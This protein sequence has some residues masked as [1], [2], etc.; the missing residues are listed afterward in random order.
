MTQTGPAADAHAARRTY[1]TFTDEERGDRGR[2]GRARRP[3]RAR[4]GGRVPGGR[5]PA[6]RPVDPR[7]A[8]VRGPARRE[9]A[10][11]ELQHV[12]KT[13]EEKINDAASR[14]A[15]SR[16]PRSSARSSPGDLVSLHPD[17]GAG[18]KTARKIYDELGI[19]TLDELRAAAESGTLQSIPGPRPEGG[20]EHPP[21]ARAGGAEAERRSR[22]LLSAVLAH[23][24]ADRRGAARASRRGPGRD[25]RQR[26]ADDRHL[27]GPRHRRD[28]ARRGRADRG[29]HGA[30]AGR[31]GAR[32][33]AR[34]A[35]GCV[36]HNGL[37]VDFR[38]VAPE[39]FGNVLQHL[40]GSKQHNMALR[41]YA[42]RR[43]QH[44]SEYGIEDDSDGAKHTCATEQE[45]YALLGLDYIE[46][47]LR[48]GRGELKAA[49]EHTLPSWSRGT[50]LAGDLHCHTTLRTAAA[51]SRRWRRRPRSA[52]TSISRSRTTRALRVR[53]RRAGGRAQRRIEKIRKLNE[54]HRGFRCSR[55]RRSTSSSTGRSTT[56]TSCSRGSTG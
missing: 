30:R 43:G 36:T 44:V 31:R 5:L 19:A 1:L 20:A 12:G 9:G 8:R 34:P 28:G 25:R 32:R 54:R 6:G 42:V 35:R 18:P 23:R 51:R 33:A 56:T 24:R 52:A 47:E 46:P 41:E 7:L 27:Q 14:P 26:A 39:Q 49:I 11:T 29:V 22:L 2:A 53:E 21:R 37:R 55:A 13:L 48:E 45:V 17:P 50:D 10:A 15:R 38:V 4:R 40:T 16:R 3:V